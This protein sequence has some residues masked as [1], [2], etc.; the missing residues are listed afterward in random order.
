MALCSAVQCLCVA[1][2]VEDLMS[3]DSE[4]K[5]VVGCCEVG[6]DALIELWIQPLKRCFHPVAPL[7]F[8]ASDAQ[9]SL[10]F[11]LLAELARTRLGVLATG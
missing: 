8:P 7:G 1:A 9:N 10:A 5:A 6:P 3:P 11:E 2:W 4:G